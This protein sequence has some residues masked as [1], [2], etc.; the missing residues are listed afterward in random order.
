MERRKFLGWVGVG[1]LASSLPVAIA[2]CSSGTDE[3][4][5]DEPPTD[6]QATDESSS[7]VAQSP[8]REDGFQSFGT[9]E[10]LDKKVTILDKKA[11]V[12]LVRNPE[13]KQ[14]SAVNPKCPH[15]GCIVEWDA[16][17]KYLNCPCHSSKF[18]ATGDLLEGPATESLPTYE[19]KEEGDLILVKL[20]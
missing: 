18:D 9:T 4:V 2:A 8:V 7:A 5:A 14:I 15:Q 20:S 6:G 13:N 10:E 11:G 1:V 12:L 19:T 17:E 16:E 3:S